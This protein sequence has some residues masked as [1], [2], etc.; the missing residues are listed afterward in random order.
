MR[1]ISRGLHTSVAAPLLGLALAGP[2]AA[3]RT[4]SGEGA[5]AARDLIPLVTPGASSPTAL[6]VDPIGYR[7]VASL[8]TGPDARDVALSPDGRFAY[9]TSFGWEPGPTAEGAAPGGPNGGTGAPS[10]Q[11]GVTV[12]DLEARSVHA[13]FQPRDYRQLG[14]AAVGEG[15]DRLWVTSEAENGVVELD[16][17]TGEVR[18]LWLTGG[19]GAADIAVTDDGRRVFTA[20]AGSDDVSVIDRLTVLSRRVPTGRRPSGLALAPAGNELWVVNS[21]DHTISVLGDFNDPKELRRFPSGGEGPVRIAFHADR[22][23]AW[24]SH[25]GSRTVTVAAMESGEPLGEIPLP[26]EPREILFS[27]DGTRAY[28]LSP[29]D[30]RV[31][32]VAVA[33]R[34]LVSSSAPATTGGP[35]ARPD[36][37]SRVRGSGGA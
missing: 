6:L 33:S 26:A 9:V 24:I 16:A 19:R 36:G 23:E 10:R 18:M 11:R 12:I 17:R 22:R 7:V 37:A 32:T 5:S 1:T 20:N 35:S 15:G 27:R 29:G 30:R 28:I 21:G 34:R 31:F 2:I 25:R 4:P 8:P 14:A 3:Q 13:V